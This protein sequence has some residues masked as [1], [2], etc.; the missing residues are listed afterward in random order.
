MT[1]FFTA[2]K[3]LTV[4]IVTLYFLMCLKHENLM[5][6]PNFSRQCIFFMYFLSK[7]LKCKK[8]AVPKSGRVS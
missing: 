8:G 4:L 2:L 7:L 1:D 3:R 6:I 5:L